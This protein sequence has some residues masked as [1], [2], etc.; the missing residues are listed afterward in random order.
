MRRIWLFLVTFCF[1]PLVV[2]ADIPASTSYKLQ[3]FGFGSGGK[4]NSSS[5]HYR[6]NGVSGETSASKL[7]GNSFKVGSGLIYAQQA[8]VP[9]APT[10]QNVSNNYNKLHFVVN[11]GPNAS[12]ALFV[13]AISADNFQ[14]DTRYIQND[15]TIGA[16]LG[17]EDY[18]TYSVWGGASGSDLIGL[19]ASTTYYVKARALHGDFT[20]TG[21]GPVA[22]AT[23]SAPYISFDVDVAPTDQETDPPFTVGFGN[24][25]PGSVNDSS[26]KVWIDLSTNAAGGGRVYVAGTNAGLNSAHTSHTIPRFTGDLSTATEGYGAQVVS[27][28]QASGGPISAVAPYNDVGSNVGQIDTTIR[29]IFSTSNPIDA[30][31]ASFQLKV[32][33]SMVAPA[34]T[35]YTDTLTLVASASF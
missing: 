25:N 26:S 20:E 6:I 33:H 16:A 8:D 1:I 4:D 27:V 11:P 5:G 35:D 24:L 30:A 3:G 7:S 17:I 19:D 32:K 14:T 28:A 2:L 21:W 29:E 23:T 15:D 34:A 9:P 13:L 12:D 31:R 22:S 18:Q 10:L